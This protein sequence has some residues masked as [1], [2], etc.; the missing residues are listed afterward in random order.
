MWLSFMYLII[1]TCICPN[2]EACWHLSLHFEATFLARPSLLFFFCVSILSL[3]VCSS[4]PFYF[5][6]SCRPANHLSFF[7][8]SVYLS[9]H[10][11]TRFWR[12]L[13]SRWQ[14]SDN[15][16]RQKQK[17][18]GKR[19]KLYSFLKPYFWFLFI[20]KIVL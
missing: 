2:C 11:T 12:E 1:T 18:N 16:K 14:R 7:L 10:L 13:Q 6:P 4:V 19:Q 9:A 5:M 15:R 8:L 20:L 17:N 3:S